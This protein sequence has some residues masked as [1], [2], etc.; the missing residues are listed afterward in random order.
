MANSPAA[1]LINEAGESVVVDELHVG[2]LPKAVGI[3][4]FAPD[5]SATY[6]EPAAG[7]KAAL[8]VDGSSQ[9]VTRSTA[10]TDEDS[11][12]SDFKTDLDADW[13][14]VESGTGSHSIADSVL[15]LSP[16]LNSSSYC[17][18]FHPGD[19]LPMSMSATVK[20]NNRER[21]VLMAMGFVNDTD[22]PGVARR[23]VVLRF[24]GVNPQT[25]TFHTQSSNDAAEATDITIPGN[26]T[27]AEW[28]NYKVEIGAGYTSAEVDGELVARHTTHLPGPYDVL[29]YG[30]SVWNR[31]AV[32]LPS[33]MYVDSLMFRNHN[34]VEIGGQFTGDP[35][36]VRL[37]E[38]PRTIL[39]DP[40]D[41]TVTA[42][43]EIAGDRGSLSTSDTA[44]QGLLESIDRTLKKIEMH[45][46]SMTNQRIS[47]SDVE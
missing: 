47:N 22:L 19:Y 11:F 40:D 28:H 33:I 13:V 18:L 16:G 27:T 17:R 15:S 32:T 23:R 9:L 41:E 26:G 24:N 3:G 46:S 7:E 25:V 14:V 5:P 8:A 39:R 34:I 42:S 30:F 36:R 4:G 10:L 2:T 38:D 1:L 21:S 45:L 12:Y 20:V 6:P 35:L 37:Q 31:H 43:M 44:A 29:G